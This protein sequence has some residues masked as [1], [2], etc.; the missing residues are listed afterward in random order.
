MKNQETLTKMKNMRLLGMHRAFTTCLEK[1]STENY[2][3]CICTIFNDFLDNFI[4]P[5]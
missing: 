4:F 3:K 5:V 2:T 1:G